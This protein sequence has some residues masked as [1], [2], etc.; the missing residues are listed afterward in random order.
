MSTVRSILIIFCLTIFIIVS[1]PIQGFLNITNTKYKKRFPLFFYKSVKAIIGLHIIKKNLDT[2]KDTGVSQGILYVA[3]HVSW[4]DIICLGSILNAR[5]IA[6]KEVASMGIFGFLSTLSNTVYIDNEN[7][8]RVVEYNKFI[9]EKL[10]NGE[11][12]IIFPEGTTSDGN[13]VLEFKSSAFSSVEN[14]DFTIQPIVIVYSDLN[15]IPIN[16]WLRPMIAWYGDMDLK[17]HLLKLVGLM[18]IKVKLFY[19]EPVNTKNFN[20]RKC[21]SKYLEDKIRKVYSSTLSKKLAK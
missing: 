21:L 8:K 18:S 11:N 15:G 4:F 3:N 2:S 17:P 19:L 5:F 16:R 20:N 6:K 7:K 14:Q 13:R 12:F 1:I 10:K 9:N